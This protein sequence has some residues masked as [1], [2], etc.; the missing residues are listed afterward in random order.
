MRF[1]APTFHEASRQWA[2]FYLDSGWG[3][4]DVLCRSGSI[5]PP[6]MRFEGLGLE[7]S[8]SYEQAGK[9]DLAG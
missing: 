2:G 8:Q 3:A 4:Q 7:A 5:G 6:A 1:R 9:L